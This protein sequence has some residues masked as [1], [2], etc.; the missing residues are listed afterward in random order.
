VVVV[1]VRMRVRTRVRVRVLMLPVW[2]LL[3]K[4]GFSN[5]TRSHSQGR[6][7]RR[8][9]EEEVVVVVGWQR[10]HSDTSGIG[11]NGRCGIH[12]GFDA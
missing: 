4:P 2:L 6:R 10:C 5:T 12:L 8:L 9:M 1:V 7:R 11:G 3:M